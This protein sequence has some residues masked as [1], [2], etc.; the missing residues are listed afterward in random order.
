MINLTLKKTKQ[1]H[2]VLKK[3]TLPAK[4]P[5][6]RANADEACLFSLLYIPAPALPVPAMEA[7]Y[8]AIVDSKGGELQPVE[9]FCS[10][11]NAVKIAYLLWYAP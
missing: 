4:F 1:Q 3:K 5:A 10:C 9:R 8:Q 11:S 6:E 7:T 2:D